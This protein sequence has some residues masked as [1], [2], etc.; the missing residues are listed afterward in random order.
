[1]LQESQA[2]AAPISKHN[3]CYAQASA[4]QEGARSHH[5]RARCSGQPQ[6]SAVMQLIPCSGHAGILPAKARRAQDTFPSATSAPPQMWG[7]R[8]ISIPTGLLQCWMDPTH[9]W[10]L[11]SIHTSNNP[12]IFSNPTH[13][14][15]GATEML[16]GGKRV[17]HAYR[18]YP[19][20]GDQ[21]PPKCSTVT[22]GLFSPT[23]TRTRDRSR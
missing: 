16:V 12:L 14:Q 13:C 3:I 8:A 9:H 22:T 15:G 6:H 17:F 23:V 20:L 19:Q 4:S 2:P 18:S 10:K 21:P 1:M 7:R 5:N 11:G